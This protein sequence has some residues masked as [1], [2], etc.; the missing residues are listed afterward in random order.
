MS[1]SI[2][3]VFPFSLLIALHG[4]C[5]SSS[6]TSLDAGAADAGSADV[7]SA[8]TGKLVT[9][10]V[11]ARPLNMLSP[12]EAQKVC[13][14]TESFTLMLVMQEKINDLICRIGGLTAALAVPDMQFRSTCEMGYS[15][16]K[17][18]PAVMDPGMAGMCMK[19]DAK[20]LATVAEYEACMNALPADLES[21][22][23]FVPPCERANK[24]SLLPLAAFQNFLGPACVTFDK[25]CPGVISGLTMLTAPRP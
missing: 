21:I 24:L 11:G 7:G 13:M 12:D 10:V 15:T 9:N 23:R 16:C 25:Q 2:A 20:C 3:F 14:A 4:G 6:S 22:G 19:A 1:K 8:A 18:A 5:G 17:M